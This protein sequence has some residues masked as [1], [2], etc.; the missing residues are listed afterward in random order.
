MTSSPNNSIEPDV[1]FS[2]PVQ[3]ALGPWRQSTAGRPGTRRQPVRIDAFLV[4]DRQDH[5]P[6][7][8]RGESI[9]RLLRFGAVAGDEGQAA[10]DPAAAGLRPPE[11]LIGTIS[12]GRAI[13]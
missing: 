7:A 13:P 12:W 3:E 8:A 5:Q 2:K 9:A 4:R 11:G 1:G 6:D 10:T